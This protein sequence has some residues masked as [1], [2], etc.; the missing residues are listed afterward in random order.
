MEMQKGKRRRGKPQGALFYQQC[1]LLF[2][3][4]SEAHACVI[5]S[6]YSWGSVQMHL[7]H[8]CGG[9]GFSS[10]GLKIMTLTAEDQGFL[11]EPTIWQK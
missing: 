3:R 11:T 2:M 6:G 4:A 5:G 8:L 10:L 1:Q 9:G 7:P